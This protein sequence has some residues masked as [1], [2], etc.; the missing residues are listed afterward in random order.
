[1]LRFAVLAILFAAVCAVPI[2][3]DSNS[4][5]GTIAVDSID[6]YFAGNPELNFANDFER[7]K[8]KTAIVPYTDMEN[9][10]QV[11][12]ILYN[13]CL[14]LLHKIRTW[15]QVC[16]RQLWFASNFHSSYFR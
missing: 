15:Y 13:H 11:R 6:E 7:E 9:A 8:P 3:Q 12:S 1:M 10:S 14:C 5:D 16:C 4:V 2:N